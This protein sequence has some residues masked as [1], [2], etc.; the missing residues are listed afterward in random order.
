MK[1]LM[2]LCFYVNFKHE[3]TCFY[4]NLPFSAYFNLPPLHHN[5]K[6]MNSFPFR[7]HQVHECWL[8]KAPLA[9]PFLCHCQRQGLGGHCKHL[10]QGSA[11]VAAVQLYAIATW[12]RGLVNYSW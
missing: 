8:H 1:T 5:G 12:R 10:T 11:Q 9:V 2:C 6:G 4:V 7:A 3:S